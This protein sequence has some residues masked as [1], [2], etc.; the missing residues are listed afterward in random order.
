MS[1]LYQ[2]KIDVTKIDKS[3]LYK[4]KKGTYLNIN[5]WVNDQPNEYGQTMSIQQKT[6]QGE[7]VIYLGNGEQVQLTKKTKV[8]EPEP[9]DDL[10][11]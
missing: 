2:A 11:F 10:P 5:V 1:K 4:G 6:A 8:S 3:K 9:E 7:P